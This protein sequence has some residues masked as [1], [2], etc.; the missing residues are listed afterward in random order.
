MNHYIYN[1]NINYL[2][3]HFI[4][5]FLQLVFSEKKEYFLNR[6]LLNLIQAEITFRYTGYP[7]LFLYLNQL[8]CVVKVLSIV[9][10]SIFR[11]LIPSIKVMYL[12]TKSVFPLYI[13]APRYAR[14]DGR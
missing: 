12:S 4:F 11:K 13:S 3:V 10:C 9:C 6:R 14:C 1:N 5:F 7:F 8:V 2:F